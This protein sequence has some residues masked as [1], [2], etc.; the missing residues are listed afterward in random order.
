MV[1]ASGGRVAYQRPV[2][3]RSRPAYFEF[4]DNDHA[5][6]SASLPDIAV[7]KKLDVERSSC[8]QLP[9]AT[10]LGGHWHPVTGWHR[11][12]TWRKPNWHALWTLAMRE[13]R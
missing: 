9:G 3:A 5:R 11:R 6:M 8:S 12:P 2:S 4:S 7:P 1:N 10:S 13:G